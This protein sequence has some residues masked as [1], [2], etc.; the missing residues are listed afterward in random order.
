MAGQLTKIKIMPGVWEYERKDGTKG[1]YLRAK[2]PR[3]GKNEQ[4]TVNPPKGSENG[5]KLS[6]FLSTE[7]SKFK[8]ELEGGIST[9]SSKTSFVEY[10]EG[11]YT[12]SFRGANKTW[13]GYYGLYKRHIKE[14]MGNLKLSELNKNTLVDYF[15]YL[16]EEKQVGDSTYNA[17]YRLLHIVLNKAV[18]DD[19][20]IKNPLNGRIVKKKNTPPKTRAM[21][22]DELNNLIRCL[23]NESLMWRTLYMLT[24]CTACRRGEIIGLMW[25][26]VDLDSDTPSIR[27]NRSVEY[28][29]GKGVS[30]VKPKTPQS[31]RTVYIPNL[32]RDLLLEMR[33]KLDVGFLF[34]SRSDIFKPMHPDS[35]NKHTTE[36][37]KK[38]DLDHFSMHVLRRTLPTTLATHGNTDPKTLQSILGHSDIRT[39]LK[40]YVLPDDDAQKDAI[41]DYANMFGFDNIKFN[42]NF[43]SKTGEA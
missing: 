27:I 5:R 41:K 39:L 12:K 24:I 15:R 23:E 8:R 10:F 20:L 25:D 6:L 22:K 13:D 35:V 26:D 42:P 1:Y 38:Y 32:V 3:T 17:I 19:L 33:S 21:K 14:W 36:M 28:V 30:V 16:E 40:Y 7:L 9:A 43:E 18:D 4:R 29:S 34:P 37:C 11:P 31:K 2:N